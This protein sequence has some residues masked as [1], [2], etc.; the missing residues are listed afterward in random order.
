MTKQNKD[1]NE[2]HNKELANGSQ[3]GTGEAR[4]RPFFNDNTRKVRVTG[5][6]AF[7]F[8][9]MATLGIVLITLARA[10]KGVRDPFNRT[11][12]LRKIYYNVIK[13]SCP[14]GHKALRLST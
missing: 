11:I 6:L 8:A 12:G 5:F 1:R 10:E 14:D 7:A 13:N 4:F 3:P 9:L 2:I